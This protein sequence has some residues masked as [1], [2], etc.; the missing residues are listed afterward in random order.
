MLISLFLIITTSTSLTV[1]AQ[2]LPRFNVEA[3]LPFR[4]CEMN[5]W[6][7]CSPEDDYCWSLLTFRHLVW[8]SSSES[9]K[10]T[11]KMTPLSSS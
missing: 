2:L 1:R 4:N 10:M 9:M 8:M 6:L 5:Y 7:K 3:W 11:A